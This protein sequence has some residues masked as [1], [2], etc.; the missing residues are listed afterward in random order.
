M[1]DESVLRTI[2]YKTVDA[3]SGITDKRL[4]IKDDEKVSTDGNMISAPLNH[5]QVLRFVEKML[6]HILFQTN[7]ETLYQFGAAYTAKI[8]SVCQEAGQPLDEGQIKTLQ[9]LLLDLS[10][11]L[12]VRR[13]IS[14]WGLVYEGSHADIRVLKKQLAKPYAMQAHQS[15]ATLMSLREAEVAI[16]DGKFTMIVPLI[17]EALK[18]VEGKGPAAT[19]A[20]AK[21]LV[22]QLVSTILD[23]LKKQTG[24]KNSKEPTRADAL[25]ELLGEGSP[26]PKK[27][28]GYYA[29]VKQSTFNGAISQSLAQK[30]AQKALDAPVESDALDE[31]LKGTVDAMTQAVEKAKKSMGGG[32]GLSPEERITKDASAKVIFHD[33]TAAEVHSFL[34]PAAESKG[35]KKGKN[36]EEGPQVGT[37]LPEDQQIVAHL[38]RMFERVRSQRRRAIYSSGLLIDTMACV[39]RHISRRP[40]PIFKE[41]IP[42]RGF[43]VLILMD[44]SS[45]MGGQKKVQ[46]ERAGRM[47]AKALDYPFVNLHMWGFQSLE[48]GQVDIYKF[49]ADLESYD[50]ATAQVGGFT[51]LHI[52]TH[53]A[54]RF[55]APS[56]NV[57]HLFVLSDGV[58]NYHRRDGQM[59]NREQLVEFVRDEVKVARANGIGVTGAVIQTIKPQH[60]NGKT[61]MLP[62]RSREHYQKAMYGLQRHWRYL[63]AANIGLDLVK[64]VSSSFAEYLRSP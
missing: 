24:K 33:V 56:H 16:P 64:L 23:L 27:M 6:A 58:P 60:V 54:W 26:L 7:Q 46:V 48:P 45:S 34:E 15:L 49:Q 51:P 50:S 55:L 29:Q 21:W 18:K 32:N 52:A 42:G 11:I 43:D 10:N 62:D 17:D 20:V 57:R 30:D 4:W 9:R 25:K 37:L 28:Q 14:L 59:Y 36:T 12:E 44:R 13:V 35:S 2:V 38:R 61:V 5:P 22:V 31:F 39:Q 47:L 53:V 41:E 3:F 1:F 19:P 40:Q 8:T 63:D